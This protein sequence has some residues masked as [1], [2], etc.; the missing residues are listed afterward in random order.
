MLFAGY[1]GDRRVTTPR[2]VSYFGSIRYLMD[3]GG[4]FHA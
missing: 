3:I 2:E 1:I 4:L